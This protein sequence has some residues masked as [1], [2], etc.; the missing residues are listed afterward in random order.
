MDIK[1]ILHDRTVQCQN[2][3]AVYPMD[4]E[5]ETQQE[6]MFLINLIMWEIKNGK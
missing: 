2:C 4:Y 6:I 1:K 3:H 5:C